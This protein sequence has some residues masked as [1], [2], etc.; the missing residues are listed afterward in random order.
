MVERS[1]GYCTK[2]TIEISSIKSNSEEYKSNYIELMSYIKKNITM[3][4]DYENM[5]IT[6]EQTRIRGLCIN[7]LCKN[8]FEKTFRM[9]VRTG[10]YCDECTLH[11]SQQKIKDTCLE[12]YGV[13]SPLQNKEVKQKIRD[14]CLEKYGVD[15]PM[16]LDETKQ[17]IKDTCI[18]RFG[19]ESPLQNE[20]IQQKVRN[21]CIEKYGV[22]YP[23]QNEEIQQ[24]VRN[25]CMKK[26][27]VENPSQSEEVKQKVRNTCMEHF[28]VPCSFQSEEV[29]QKSKDTCLEKYGV[30]YSLQNEEVKQK[31]KDT[32]LEKYG[33]DHP[34]LLDETKQKIKD[35]CME[36]YGVESPLQNKEIKQKSKNTCMEKYGVEYS[37][38]SEEVKQK[39]RDTCIE[40]YGVEHPMH[41]SEIAEKCSKSGYRRKEYI[42]PSGKILQIQG[43]EHF[44]LDELVTLYQEDDIINGMSNVPEIWYYDEEDKKHR[45]YV[46]LFIPSKQICIEVKS[47]WTAEKKKDNIFLKQN[48]GKTLGYHYEIWVYDA[49]GNKVECYK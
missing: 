16:L 30:E 14:T 36:K 31:S 20:E 26:Y 18:K 38:Q 21:T 13:E 17:K 34:M 7:K 9:L 10:G 48:A 2:C 33:V 49:K 44:A 12:K 35:T 3:C 1:N 11:I 42:L 19:V 39:I 8:I 45:H 23:L 24:K 46:D 25:T 4:S 22:E 40:R 41:I 32:C 27:G 29:K 5:N 6:K 15:H 43:Y 37:L 47:T 28:N